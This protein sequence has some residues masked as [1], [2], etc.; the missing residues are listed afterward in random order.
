MAI[1]T[2][3]GAL[4]ALCTISLRSAEVGPFRVAYVDDDVIAL[5]DQD[6]PGVLLAP[7]SHVEALSGLSTATGDFLAALRRTVTEVQAAYGT[8]GAMIEPATGSI[9]I[10]DVRPTEDNQK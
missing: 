6:L 5:I 1:V 2:E 4:C 9:P 3:S 7:R 8:T 10:H